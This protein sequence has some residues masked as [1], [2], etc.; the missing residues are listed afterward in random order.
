MIIIIISRKSE[1]IRVHSPNMLQLTFHGMFFFPFFKINGKSSVYWFKIFV[2]PESGDALEGAS[3]WK[4]QVLFGGPVPRT[5][6]LGHMTCHNNGPALLSPKT[7]SNKEGK[8]LIHLLSQIWQKDSMLVYTAWN[9]TMI[10][11]RDL[12]VETE[13]TSV[14]THSSLWLLLKN[15]DNRKQFP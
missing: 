8:K 12:K 11:T 14:W 2:L 6:L 4:G 13:N 9:F 10:N 15:I 7:H 5:D 1:D 3:D